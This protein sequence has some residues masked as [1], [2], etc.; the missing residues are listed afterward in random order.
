MVLIKPMVDSEW[1]GGAG[2]SHVNAGFWLLISFS[3]LLL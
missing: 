2:R 1:V 3:I